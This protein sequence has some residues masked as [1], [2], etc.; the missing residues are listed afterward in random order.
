MFVI[1][2]L[3]GYL[4][5][6]HSKD[7]MAPH[8]QVQKAAGRLNYDNEHT[9]QST[10]IRAGRPGTTILH[11]NNGAFTSQSIFHALYI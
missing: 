3:R 11:V 7:I 9:Y 5:K 6:S 4:E 1:K 2:M 10:D 8:L